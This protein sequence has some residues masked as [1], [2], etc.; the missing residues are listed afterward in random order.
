MSSVTDVEQAEQL[1]IEDPKTT[2]S[3]IS[4]NC[5]ICCSS[6]TWTLDFTPLTSKKIMQYRMEFDKK[7]QR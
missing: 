5:H 3:D 6:S 4:S 1:L 7:V 2:V